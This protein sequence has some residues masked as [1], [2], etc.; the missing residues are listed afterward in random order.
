MSF[1]YEAEVNSAQT[2]TTTA[3]T[4]VATLSGVSS[5]RAGQKVHLEGHV[6]I[7]TGTSTTAVVLRIR[8]DSL[9]GTVVDTVET[10]SLAAAAAGNPEDHFISADFPGAG[11]LS[12]KT[13]VLTV[14]QTGAAANG[15]VN[16]AELRADLQP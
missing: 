16:L 4:V 10:D 5:R 15:T 1:D 9:T 7:T 3:E 12:L 6:N 13:F 11:E 8:Q 14:T 2:I